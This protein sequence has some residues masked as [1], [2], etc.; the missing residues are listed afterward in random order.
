M[1]PRS[2]VLPLAALAIG[3]LGYAI[4]GAY[5]F[6]EASRIKILEQRGSDVAELRAR[7]VYGQRIAAGLLFVCLALIVC[8]CFYMLRGQATAR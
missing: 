2:L 3:L 4:A 7:F 8:I 6:V 1:I 5:L